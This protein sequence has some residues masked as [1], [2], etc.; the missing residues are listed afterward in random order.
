MPGSV[1]KPLVIRVHLGRTPRI[2]VLDKPI[3]PTALMDKKVSVLLI[4]VIIK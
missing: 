2:T 3:A 1:V 4:S